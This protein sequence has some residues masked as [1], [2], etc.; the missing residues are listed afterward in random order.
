M[1]PIDRI[2]ARLRG[3]FPLGIGLLVLVLAGCMEGKTTVMGAGPQVTH[4][5]SLAIRQGE[6]PTT[7]PPDVANRFAS[8]LETKIYGE[9][10]VV[11]GADLTLTYRFTNYDPGNRFLRYLAPGLGVG[12]LTVNTTYTDRSGKTVATI[13]SEGEVQQGLFGGDFDQAVD[14]AVRSVASYT[15][16]TFAIAAGPKAPPLFPTPGV[17]SLPVYPATGAARLRPSAGVVAP[18][19]AEFHDTFEIGSI[20]VPLLDGPWLLAGKGIGGSSEFA[21]S[22]VRIDAGKL[23]GII[24][25]W[26]A[27]IPSPDGYASFHECTRTDVLFTSVASNTDHGAQDCW[28]VTHYDM[29]KARATSTQPHMLQSYSFLDD[30]GVTVPGTMIVGVHRIATESNFITV[31]YQVNPELAGF[32]APALTEWRESAW[33]RDRI[34][35]DPQRVAFVDG[36]KAEHAHYH[37]LLRQAFQHDLISAN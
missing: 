7:V 32:P 24:R 29:V 3:A 8:Q 31:W 4:F 18:V 11:R 35:R 5:Q 10:A 14:Q 13:V 28:V 21:A 30:R 2:T 15:L 27:A 6:A 33:H 1:T 19:G 17:A 20:Q 16:G 12:T 23:V 25:V 22:L 26:T 36:F 9:A 34:A 37:G